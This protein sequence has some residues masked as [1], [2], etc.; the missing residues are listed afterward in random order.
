LVAQKHQKAQTGKTPPT[1]TSRSSEHRRG[2]ETPKK[3]QSRTL[4]ESQP[5]IQQKD[6]QERDH[7]GLPGESVKN[8]SKGE[9]RERENI[10]VEVSEDRT[11]SI[12]TTPS[13]HPT[14]EASTRNERRYQQQGKGSEM[15]AKQ[16]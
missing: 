14:Q 12:S 2:K 6:A 16:P 13:K 4:T 1:E 8:P 3:N 9:H 15:K 10:S 7:Q 11:P 5:S